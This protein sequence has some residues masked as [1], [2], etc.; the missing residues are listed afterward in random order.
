MELIKTKQ[1][2]LMDNVMLN[3]Q[4]EKVTNKSLGFSKN[5]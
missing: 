2:N 4:P 1:I 3:H 5:N